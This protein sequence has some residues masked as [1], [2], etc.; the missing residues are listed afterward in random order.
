MNELVGEALEAAWRDADLTRRLLAFARRQPLRPARIEVNDLASDTVR[1]LRRLLGEDVEVQLNLGKDI[2]PVT[3]TAQLE[4]ALANL[5]NKARDAMPRGGRLIITTANRPLGRGTGLGLSM[6][7][8]FL[9]QSGG[10]V[11]AYS[12]LGEGT[13]FRLYLPRAVDETPVHETVEAAPAGRVAGETVLVVED[14]P[15]MRRVVLRQ[16]RE[17]G[18][19]VLDCDRAAAALELLQSE[20]IDLLLTDIVMPSGLDGVEL[21]RIA[22]ERWPA[23][24][25]V[26]TSGFPQARVEGNGDLLGGLQLLNK[27]YSKEELAAATRAA[28]DG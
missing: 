18:Y 2:W 1:L 21:A 10:H 7:F 9:K 15:G 23:L 16:L 24:R 12:E 11:N 5:A 17:L 26:L 19:R 4:A 20:K 6:V 3:A 27:P 22:H 25:I 28:L 14:N 13:T 8:G